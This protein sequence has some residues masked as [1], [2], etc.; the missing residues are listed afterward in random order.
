MLRLA[1][2][3]DI[4]YLAQRWY[5]EKAKTCFNQLD[6]EWSVTGC[7]IFLNEVLGNSNHVVMVY[8]DQG[9][10]AAC[11]ALLQ[12]NLLP[13]HPWVIGEWMWWGD[14]KRATVQVLHAAHDWGK[15]RG[16]VLAQYTLNQPSQSPTK[17]SETYRWEVL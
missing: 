3:K 8:D 11:G 6:V 2:H 15:Q 10:Q 5:D 16:A 4:P 12:R 13:P 17:F 14:N 1:T 9:I 7:A